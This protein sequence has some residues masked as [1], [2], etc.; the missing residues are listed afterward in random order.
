VATGSELGLEIKKIQDE[1][2]LVNSDILCN[3]VKHNIIY[4]RGNYLLDGFPRNAENI[5]AWERI[6]GACCTTEMLLSFECD[7]AKMEE[8]M[9]ERAK[10]SGRSDDNPE[11]IK[12]RL[13]TFHQQ[14]KP[15][16]EHFRKLNKVVP[17]DAD[18]EIEA[19]FEQVSREMKEKIMKVDNSRPQVIFMCGGPGSGKG[20]QCDLIKEQYEVQHHSPGELLRNEVTKGGPLAGKIKKIQD[21]GGLVSS[22]L[23][24]DLLKAQIAGKPGVHIVDGFP[25][26]FENLDMWNKKMIHECDTKFMLF[27]DCSQEE[28]ERRVLNR[29]QGR[30]DDNPETMKKRIGTFVKITTPLCEWMDTQKKL[31]KIS[32]NQSKEE[33][34]AEVKKCMDANL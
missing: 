23:V 29:G 19:V 7:Q 10:T 13:D 18:G 28:M 5:E 8:R 22:D 11:T 26:G 30:S 31:V 25:R 1:G 3:I 9:L 15:I 6:M 32:A 14:T 17:I 4:K 2:G 27:F 20:T 33:I 12:K 16:I 24:V 21:N 34:F